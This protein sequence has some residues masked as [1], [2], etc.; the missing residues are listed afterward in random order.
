[1]GI[2]IGGFR[3]RFEARWK[4]KSRY[5]KNFPVPFVRARELRRHLH[6][7]GVLTYSFAEFLKNNHAKIGLGKQYALTQEQVN[8]AAAGAELHDIGKEKSRIGR[9]MDKPRKL[10]AHERLRTEKHV[11]EGIKGI[12]K[13][14]TKNR[15][16]V[17]ELLEIIDAVGNHHEKW[18]GTGYPNKAK[19]KR[20]PLTARIIS[21]CD[22]FCARTENRKYFEN[23]Q[24]QSVAE[25]LNE[26]N[27]LGG[28]HFDPGLT[29]AFITYM[30]EHG[31]L[32]H[33]RKVRKGSYAE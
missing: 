3:K 24:G 1:M 33:F 21:I 27:K 20:I 26:I 8:L 29:K 18:D 25:I 11:I 6:D 4:R 12:I 22:V 32:Q 14:A 30:L 15:L 10:T 28:T 9:I 19:G 17:K 31:G 13:H 23:R 16:N 7:V 2:I 5:M